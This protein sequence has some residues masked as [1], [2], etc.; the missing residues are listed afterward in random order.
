MAD[1]QLSFWTGGHKNSGILVLCM[2]SY[3]HYI[4]TG[5]RNYGEKTKTS[6]V[7]NDQFKVMKVEAQVVNC[8]A[9]IYFFKNVLSYLYYNQV[10]K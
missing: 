8:A 1:D 7:L 5:N 10:L 4:L 2:S 9:K 3:D 6:F